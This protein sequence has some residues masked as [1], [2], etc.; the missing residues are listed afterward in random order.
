MAPFKI[1]AFFKISECVCT[2]ENPFFMFKGCSQIL[3]LISFKSN[4]CITSLELTA[5]WKQDAIVGSSKNL[6]V[7]LTKPTL[8]L[9]RYMSVRTCLCFVVVKNL[10]LQ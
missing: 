7:E 8:L 3:F 5:P 1:T 9:H 2:N 6:G 4:F 10:L